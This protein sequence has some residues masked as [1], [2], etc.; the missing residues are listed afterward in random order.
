MRPGDAWEKIPDSNRRA[1]IDAKRALGISIE[2]LK[3]RID[4]MLDPGVIGE[5]ASF[6]GVADPSSSVIDQLKK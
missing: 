4:V 1:V 2:H 6:K 5:N 3:T